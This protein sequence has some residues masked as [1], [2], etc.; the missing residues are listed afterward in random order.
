MMSTLVDVKMT[1]PMGSRRSVCD[2]AGRA[3]RDQPPALQASRDFRYAQV[4]RCRSRSNGQPTT[5][6]TPAVASWSS[7]YIGRRCLSRDT[8]YREREPAPNRPAMRVGRSGGVPCVRSAADLQGPGI[9]VHERAPGAEEEQAD[10]GTAGRPGPR[11]RIVSTGDV[12]RVAGLSSLQLRCE[13]PPRP[14][15][16]AR[17]GRPSPSGEVPDI[18]SRAARSAAQ[19]AGSAARSPAPTARLRRLQGCR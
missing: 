16:V 10:A 15:R 9:S 18:R 12:C 1:D 3:I 8:A 5:T 7:P 19:S 6:V 17:A 2:A 14:G 4:A 11:W 13:P